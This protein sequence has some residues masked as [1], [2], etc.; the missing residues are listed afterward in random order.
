LANR[1]QNDIYQTSMLLYN[2]NTS[3]TLKWLTAFCLYLALPACGRA[4]EPASEY[5]PYNPDAPELADIQLTVDE[6]MDTAEDSLKM[7]GT[8]RPFAVALTA[9]DSI[10][11][12]NVGKTPGKSYT[13]KDLEEELSIDALNGVYKVVSIFYL[14]SRTYE[15]GAHSKAVH[16]HAEHTNDDFAY[17]FE[18]PF[19]KTKAEVT[20]EAPT[21]RYEQQEMYKP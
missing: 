1:H 19:S 15:P 21:A 2:R 5:P 8:F 9:D 4:Q 14:D 3:I 6:G 10:A 18:Y 20:F 11:V 7:S 13:A 17:H 12:I 16:I